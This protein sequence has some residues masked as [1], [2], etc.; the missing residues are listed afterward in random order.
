MVRLRLFKYFLKELNG[1][2]FSAQFRPE[3]TSFSGG[4]SSYFTGKLLFTRLAVY[5]IYIQVTQVNAL[6]RPCM[7]VY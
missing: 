1:S 2:D 6:S 4:Q 7:G 5:R 3:L